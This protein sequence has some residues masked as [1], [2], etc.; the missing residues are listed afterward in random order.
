TRLT[1]LKE[2][3]ITMPEPTPALQAPKINGDAIKERVEEPQ[4]DL[5]EEAIS[6]P[7][8]EPI[9]KSL[10][11]PELKLKSIEEPQSDLFEEAI[12]QPVE[13][14]YSNLFETIEPQPEPSKENSLN[15]M[16]SEEEYLLKSSAIKKEPSYNDPTQPKYVPFINEKPISNKPSISEPMVE[17]AAEPKE[18]IQ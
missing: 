4:P 12:S 18:N 17:M 15:P 1:P 3:K 9:L 13:E 2:E 14:S 8:E 6:Q 11:E 16:E 7:I 5:F 10:N